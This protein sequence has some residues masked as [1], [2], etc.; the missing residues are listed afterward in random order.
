MDLNS[1]NI[2]IPVKK[3]NVPISNDKNVSQDFEIS[4][5]SS[6]VVYKAELTHR[7][8]LFSVPINGPITS[9]VPINTPVN[10]TDPFSA[11]HDSFSFSPNSARIIFTSMHT[12]D[13]IELWS[14][15]AAGPAS[16]AV[17]LNP[18]L[19]KDAARY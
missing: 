2:P 19:V 12:P 5:D 17:K 15:P 13:L 11:V 7:N 8:N 3:L 6:R 1:R 10:P 4:P 18:P 16:A 14:V 9:N